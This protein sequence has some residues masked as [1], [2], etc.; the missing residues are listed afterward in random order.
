M[1]IPNDFDSCWREDPVSGCFVWLRARKGKEASTGGGYGC[2][3]L[4]GRTA[5]AHRFAY[6]RAHGPIPDGLCVMHLCHNSLCVNP[7]HLAPGTNRQNQEMKAA[8]GRTPRRLT[9]AIVRD[10]RNRHAAGELQR[11]LAAEHGLQQADVSN[12][13]NRKYWK[14]VE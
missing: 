5:A 14:H 6:E 7:A 13:V 10:I 12:I 1:T 8:A 3:K 4:K 9:P 2:F 11:V